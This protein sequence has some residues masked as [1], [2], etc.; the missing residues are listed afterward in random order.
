MVGRP[1][2][3]SRP[4]FSR[5]DWCRIYYV[6]LPRPASAFPGSFHQPHSVWEAT[7]RLRGS[8]RGLR[9][10]QI[11]TGQYS[12]VGVLAMT[13]STRYVDKGSSIKAG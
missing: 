12:C 11:E 8:T 1:Q 9:V 3:T 5:N 10:Y 4:I 2:T 13:D 7:E 6:S